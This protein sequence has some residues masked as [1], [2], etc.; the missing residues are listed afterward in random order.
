MLYAKALVEVKKY[1]QSLKVL[2]S[3]TVLPSELA[4][5]SRNIYFDAHV[6]LAHQYIQEKKY[7]KAI[8]LLNDS[9]EWPEHLGVGRPYNADNRLQDYLL[10]ICFEKLKKDSK[11]NTLL[12]DV[13]N[14]TNTA[15]ADSSL[16]ELFRLLAL[17]KLGRDTE[18]NKLVSAIE[19]SIS[20]NEETNKL[21]LA[22][23]K[24]DSKNLSELKKESS[25]SNGLWALLE[26][27][28]GY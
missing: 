19:S 10:A 25:L 22:F 3:T 20:K 18:L 27:S 4:M 9:K 24:K 17:K 11:R 28:V 8:K 6:F 5:L 26:T 16:N 14:Y 23:L 15:T 12:E 1:H 7:T 21:V 2:K 13:I